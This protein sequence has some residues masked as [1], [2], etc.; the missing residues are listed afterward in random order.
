MTQAVRPIAQFFRL[1]EQARPP[2]RA[3]RSAMGTLPTRAFRYCEAATS[4]SGYGWW[5][6]PPMDMQIMWDGA[7]IYWHYDGA[8]DWLKLMPS[9]QFP[10][11]ADQFDAN[12]P[13]ELQGY[14]PPFLTALPEA[15]SLQ[16]WTGLIARTA[17][18]W[19]LLLRAPANLPLPGGFA[20]Y[21]GIVESDRWFGP[22]F[23]NLR[24]TRSHTP[25]R[26]RADFPLLQAQPVRPLDYANETLSAMSIASSM[27]EFA[28]E[29]WEAYRDTV[30]EPNRRPDRPFG[31]Y[32]IATRK[33]RKCPVT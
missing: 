6:S 15:G 12:A 31:A 17:P 25:I 9:A 13:A 33:Q 27:A 16:L 23:T 4:A 22:L 7:D 21:E 11:F 20:Q 18:D 24:F 5:I 10:G 19:H 26:L 14:A 32:A 8:E 28:A 3:D 1:I 2:Q 30:V 29:A